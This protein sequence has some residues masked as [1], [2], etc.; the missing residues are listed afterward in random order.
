[1]LTREFLLECMDIAATIA[2][3]GSDVLDLFEQNGRMQELVQGL[4]LASKTLLIYSSARKSAGTRSKKLR[5][6]G[7]SHD[8]WSVKP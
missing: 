1:V 8:L 7:W 3:E 4:A 6:R 2:E 5:L